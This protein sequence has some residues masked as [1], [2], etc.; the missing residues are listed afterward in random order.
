MELMV[1]IAELMPLVCDSTHVGVLLSSYF[2]TRNSS[3]YSIVV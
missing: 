1:L 3:G 2:A